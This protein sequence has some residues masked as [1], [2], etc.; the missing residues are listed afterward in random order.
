MKDVRC[1]VR[2]SVFFYQSVDT[3]S[4]VWRRL[5]KIALEYSDRLYWIGAD[6]GFCVSNVDWRTAHTIAAQI[7]VT[8]LKSECD[9]VFKEMRIV[10][11]EDEKSWHENSPLG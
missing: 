4:V 9:S 11:Q 3:E 10:V 1:T 7:A 8:V 6:M 5:R 2:V